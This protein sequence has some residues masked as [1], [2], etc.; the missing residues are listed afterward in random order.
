LEERQKQD[1]AKIEWLRGAAKVGF[2]AI[3]QGD[4]VTLHSRKEIEDLIDRIGAEV[5]AE[6]AP[7]RK[8]A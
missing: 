3:A 8:R 5:S 6:L 4:Y 1:K 2:D 7:K